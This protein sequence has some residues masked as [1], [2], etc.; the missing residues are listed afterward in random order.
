MK[1][2]SNFFDRSLS[3]DS[4]NANK[5]AL[6]SALWGLGKTLMKVKK[7]LSYENNGNT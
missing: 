7:L 4:A 5:R 2:K 3:F 6:E 1:Q